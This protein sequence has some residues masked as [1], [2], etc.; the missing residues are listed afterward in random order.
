MLSFEKLHTIIVESDRNYHSEGYRSKE[1]LMWRD[2]LQRNFN[3]INAIFKNVH[4]SHKKFEA[5]HQG[6]DYNFVTGYRAHMMQQARKLDKLQ[7][8]IDRATKALEGVIQRDDAMESWRASGDYKTYVKA[9]QTTENFIS[10]IVNE[11]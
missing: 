1:F 9:K 2:I 3:E 8:E 11:N 10:E 4:D 6:Q 5:E 7:K